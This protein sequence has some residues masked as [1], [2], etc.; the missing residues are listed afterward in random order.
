M[1]DKREEECLLLRP[2][3]RVYQEINKQRGGGGGVR[4]TEDRKV[5]RREGVQISGST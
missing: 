4:A 2:S 1:S 3:M 5:N